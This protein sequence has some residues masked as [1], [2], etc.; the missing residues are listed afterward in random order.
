MTS[1]FLEDYNDFIQQQSTLI[2]SHNSAEF[3]PSQPAN[4]VYRVDVQKNVKAVLQLNNKDQGSLNLRKYAVPSNSLVHDNKVL[5]SLEHKM[6][7][8]IT[9]ALKHGHTPERNAEFE[10]ARDIVMQLKKKIKR[11]VDNENDYG[12]S[13]V[14]EA[15]NDKKK[16]NDVPSPAP[17]PNPPNKKETDVILAHIVEKLFKFTNVDE[18]KSS[19]RSKPTYASKSEIVAKISDNEELKKLAPKNYKTVGKEQL[20]E[21]LFK[22]T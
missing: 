4:I 10:K 17:T 6:Q 9:G 20:C 7:E 18:C 12:F 8:I 5:V 21:S 2:N 19:K 11:L 16:P 1:S 13:L 15:V 14:R 22:K 3:V